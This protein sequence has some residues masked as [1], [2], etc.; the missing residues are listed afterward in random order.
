MKQK[1]ENT[2]PSECNKVSVFGVFVCSEKVSSL[3]LLLVCVC[4]CVF[5]FVCICVCMCIQYW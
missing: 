5:V 1:P 3:L 4:V 2:L